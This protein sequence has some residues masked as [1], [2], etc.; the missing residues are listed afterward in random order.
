[1]SIGDRSYL[2]NL[3]FADDVVLIAISA[4]QVQAMLQDLQEAATKRG[5]K[6][7]SGKTKVLTNAA[8]VTATRVPSS[9]TVHGESYAVLGY[10]V[11]TKYLGRK[12][13]YDDPHEAEFSNR[14]A[15]AWGAFSKHK[16]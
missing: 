13:R 4:K 15:A 3:C 16:S 14:V 9:I 1:M 2:S 11:S 12:V 10:N 5:L 7:H 8:A 6:I